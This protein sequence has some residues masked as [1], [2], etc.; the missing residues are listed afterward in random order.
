MKE[1]DVLV[2]GPTFCDIIFTG[3]PGMPQLGREL[4]ANDLTLSLGGSA[5]IASGLRQLGLQVGLIADLGSDPFSRMV[6]EL[7]EEKRIDR[8]LIRQHQGALKQVTVALSYPE[9][10]AFVTRFEQPKTPLNLEDILRDNTARHLHICSFLA[11]VNNP[12]APEIAHAAHMTVSGDFGWDEAAL[13]DPKLKRVLAELDIF[14]PSKSELLQ[15]AGINE[16]IQAAHK[17]FSMMKVGWLVVKDGAYGAYGYSSTE[18]VHVPAIPIQPFETTGA[19][20]AF[21]AGFI[22]AYLHK[23]PLKI[24]MQ[25][26]AICGGLTTTL[27]GGTNGFPTIEELT[28]WL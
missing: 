17:V 10:R 5:I 23:E 8:S 18:K 19:G 25:Y 1:Y 27:P 3:I 14:L 7:L 22:Y 6:W 2:Y 4:F 21:D 9:D 11:A 13:R 12:Y 15:I 26:G 20:D 16:G 24:C 28:S